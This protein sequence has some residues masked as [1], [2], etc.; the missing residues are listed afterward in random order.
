MRME[1][2]EDGVFILGNY[3]PINLEAGKERVRAGQGWPGRRSR[4]E[5]V[6]S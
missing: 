2:E 1:A 4:G 3:G 6:M 5:E